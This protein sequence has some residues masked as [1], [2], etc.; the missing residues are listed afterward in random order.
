MKKITFLLFLFT[1]FV[2]S[3]ETYKFESKFHPEKKYTLKIT[4]SSSNKM[5]RNDKVLNKATST[6]M[7]RT[8]TTGKKISDGKFPA[9]MEF[10]DVIFSE[11]G[12]QTLNSLSQTIINGSF[13][14]YN[15]FVIDTILNSKI[16]QKTRN[17]L[18]AAFKNLK[19]EI[20][21]P[22]KPLKIGDSFINKIPMNIPIE[23]KQINML[24][25]KT[26]TLKNVQN[27]IAEFILNEIITMGAESLE[28]SASG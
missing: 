18:K 27:N 15:K 20:D 3:Q 16:D 4:V 12:K 25:T 19:P 14:E 1:L 21:F 28:M 23:G 26:F 17:I 11:N 2:H 24:M 7:I 5:A 9:T 22:E 6:E 8:P 10:G 13:T